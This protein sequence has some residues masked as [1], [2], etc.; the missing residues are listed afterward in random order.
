MTKKALLYKR[1]EKRKEEKKMVSKEMLKSLQELRE[2]AYEEK[3]LAAGNGKIEET[4]HKIHDYTV[5]VENGFVERIFNSK[6]ERVYFYQWSNYSNAYQLE[7]HPKFSTL[8]NGIY[9]GKVKLV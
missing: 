6:G 3:K 9:K 1:K 4:T 8:K 7:M 5:E 2:K